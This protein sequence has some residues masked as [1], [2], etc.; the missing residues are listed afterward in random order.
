MIYL[1]I[2]NKV[3]LNISNLSNKELLFVVNSL[4]SYDIK[5]LRNVY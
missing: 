1:I 5:L 2:N 4:K 3:R